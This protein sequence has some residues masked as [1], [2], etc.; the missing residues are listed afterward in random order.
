M[1]S[2]WSDAARATRYARHRSIRDVGREIP[3]YEVDERGG[4]R[5]L[6]KP[7]AVYPEG[8][9]VTA[10]GE[11][12][13]S[14]FL[15]DLPYFLNDLRRSG[16]LGR[17]LPKRHPELILPSDVRN[18]SADHCLTYLTRFGWELAGNLILGDGAFRRYLE[19]SVEG[20]ATIR[21]S[22]RNG[23]R[24]VRPRRTSGPR[25]PGTGWCHGPSARSPPRTRRPS[26]SLAS[27]RRG[28]RARD[29]QPWRPVAVPLP[30][31]VPSCRKPAQEC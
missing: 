31:W 16:F 14:R 26:A 4:A 12:A 8:F 22:R 29:P 24:S 1:S 20:P 9:Y 28:S 6:C 17:L 2:S 23:T 21:P 25:L 10:T 11:G 3:V 5:E 18:W 19:A 15:A 27:S 30:H 7:V 13:T